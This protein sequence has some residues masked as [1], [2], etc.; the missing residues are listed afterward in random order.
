MR[1]FNATLQR[2]VLLA[3]RSPAEV[4]N[5][6]FF[7]VVVVSLFPLAVSPTP[8]L[9]REMAP[10]VIWVAALLAV[11][12]SLDGLF[13][14]DEETGVLDQLLVAPVELYF[15][16]LAKIVAHWLLVGLPL[17]LVA[18]VLGYMLQLPVSVLGTLMWGL[19]LGTPS[20]M[21]IGAIGAS[22]T[23]GLRRG[24]ML[25]AL[26]V[27][28]LY[29]PVLVF[30]AGSL[31]RALEA[32]PVNPVLAVLGAVLALALSLGPFAI[33]LGLRISTGD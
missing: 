9:L 31:G 12:L 3:M 23:V 17:V 2:E 10:G 27:L 30:G 13:R 8:D 32:L 1:G 20:L 25:L 26:L 24:S 28:P 16:V 15:T 29:I 14:T 33:A 19:L 6:L 7:F 5:P 22:L 18:P 4:I 11:M 21:V